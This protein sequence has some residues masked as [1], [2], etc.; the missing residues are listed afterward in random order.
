MIQLMTAP[1]LEIRM[2][3]QFGIQFD[4]VEVGQPTIKLCLCLAGNAKH[5]E[6]QQ[7]DRYNISV[8]HDCK[9]TIKCG[10]RSHV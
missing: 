2:Y 10:K 8:L 3:A 5:V 6:K 4:R 7:T 9:K 1:E